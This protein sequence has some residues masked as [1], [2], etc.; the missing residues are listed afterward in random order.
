[1]QAVGFTKSLPIS[2]PNSLQEFQIERPVATGHDLLI[3]VSAVSVNPVDV[4]QRAN[5]GYD[6]STPRILGFDGVGTVTAVG[7]AVSLFQVGERVYY[8]GEVTRPG[9]DAEYELVDERIV[10]LAPKTLDDADAA[11]IPLTGLTAWEALFEILGIDPADRAGNRR[12]TILLINGAGGAGSMAVQLAHWAG[13]HVIASAS[14]PE[15]SAWVTKLGAD[16]VV[17]H[18]HNLINEV[19]ARGHQNVN[20]IFDL[21]SVDRHWDEMTELIAPA[22]RM[23][24]ITRAKTPLALSPLKDKRASFGWELVFSK[25]LYHTPDLI[26]Q[27]EILT[28]I[29]RLLDQGELVPTTTKVLTPLTV[30]NLKAAH[31][32][33]ESGRMIGKVVVANQ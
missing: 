5:T 17:N 2:D 13:L 3:R 7:D 28:K 19:R 1:M 27:H 8:S 16:E 20:Y 15:T 4:L 30:A 33:V 29:A 31:E 24:S 14:R 23:V 9:S 32:A 10:A 18:R 11:A 22:G 26:S 25:A 12:R 6:E 21:H